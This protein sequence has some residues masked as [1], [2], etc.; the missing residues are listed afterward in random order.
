MFSRIIF[1]ACLLL[2]RKQISCEILFLRQSTEVEQELMWYAGMAGDNSEFSKRASGAYIFRPNGTVA[3]S[4]GE[5]THKIYSGPVVTEVHT[6]FSS[7][8]SQVV[9]VFTDDQSESQEFHWMV[10]PIPIKLVST[11]YMFN[12]YY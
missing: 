10:G 11:E 5:P 3:N 9:R 8:A 7:W 6:T 1:Y 4:F 2:I 12:I